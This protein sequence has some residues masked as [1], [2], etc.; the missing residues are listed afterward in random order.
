VVPLF[1]EEWRNPKH[2]RLPHPPEARVVHLV[3]E[4][5]RTNKR[6]ERTPRALD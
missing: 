1:L 5:A 3:S 2:P 4:F 6:I